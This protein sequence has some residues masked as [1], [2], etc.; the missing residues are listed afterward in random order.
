MSDTPE[1]D[2]AERMAY[3]NE[4]MVPTEFAQKLERERNDVTN[5]R[6]ADIDEWV[7]RCALKD[8]ECEKLERERD[9]AREVLEAISLYL[10]VG[11]GDESTTAAQYHERIL[12]GMKMLTDP[13]I[14]KWQAVGKE[15]DE[16]REDA[17]LL[18]ERLTRL[19]LDSSKALAKLERERDEALEALMKIEE[20]FIDGEDTYEDWKKMG[21]IATDYLEGL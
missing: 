3:S 17:R 9:E 14:E 7:E 1:T 16:A 4:Y 10:S 20:I 15:R 11:M 21:N 18:A 19:E 12:E 8:Q 13:L 6:D 2:K 5:H